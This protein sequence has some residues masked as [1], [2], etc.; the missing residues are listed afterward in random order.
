MS[1]NVA[2]WIKQQPWVMLDGAMGSL[3][4][5]AGIPLGT[6]SELWNAEQPV[7][8]AAIY[9]AYVD[10]GAQIILT[11]S[12]GGSPFRLRKHE[13]QDRMLELNR[14]A[15]QIARDVVQVSDHQIFVAG[16]IVLRAS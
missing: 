12:F 1:E 6:P 5:A 10:A 9:Q 14:A 16:S 4:I 8:I 2:S 7:E 3:L 15:A 11:N 13:L